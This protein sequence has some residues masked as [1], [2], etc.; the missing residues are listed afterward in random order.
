MYFNQ[1]ISY[2]YNATG[3]KIQGG[4]LKNIPVGYFSERATLPRGKNCK[5]S[6]YHFLLKTKTVCPPPIIETAFPIL[7]MYYSFS[8]PNKNC[9]FREVFLFL[10]VSLHFSEKNP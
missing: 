5:R 7:T 1:Y 9:P 3:E 8:P 4:A 6:E 10:T 2:H